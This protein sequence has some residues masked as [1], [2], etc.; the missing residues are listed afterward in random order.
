MEL[1]TI[2]IFR[3]AALSGSFTEAARLLFMA[4][5]NISMAMGA[6]ERELDCQLFIR[7]R[8]G[9]KLS[10]AGQELFQLSEGILAQVDEISNIGKKTKEPVGVLRMAAM[11]STAVVRLP[12]LFR[13]FTRQFGRIRIKLVTG[14]TRA[15]LEMLR[16][17]E[18]DFAFPG[19]K[20]S[21]PN[22]GFEKIFEE[23]L[24]LARL[25]S[26]GGAGRFWDD[27]FL[28]L[29]PGCSFRRVLEGELE[30]RKK[31]AR[32]HELGGIHAIYS[33][34]LA[35]MGSSLFT[36]SFLHYHRGSGAGIVTEALP[37]KSG[38]LTIYGAWRKDLES[39]GPVFAWRNFLQTRSLS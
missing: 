22:L 37:G 23:N 38:S 3:Q 16:S 6:L 20:E 1:Q 25:E 32:L 36:E 34:V 4:Q 5:S 35:G 27:E 8:R 39:A 7:S 9:V 2:R 14:D 17:G 10:Q 13:E 29:A 26:A 11:E 18:V 21:G 15:Q 28:V 30:K 24:V 19:K 31:S 12:R 33:G